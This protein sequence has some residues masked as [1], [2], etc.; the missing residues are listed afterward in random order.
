M[1]TL[2]ENNLQRL[3]LSVV[4]LEVATGLFSST[5][6]Q[7]CSHILF[8]VFMLL[9]RNLLHHKDSFFEQVFEFCNFSRFSDNNYLWFST[10]GLLLLHKNYG[11]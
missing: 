8:F 11:K 6:L 10:Q 1:D 4:V 3:F 9:L 5:G 7:I 2:H